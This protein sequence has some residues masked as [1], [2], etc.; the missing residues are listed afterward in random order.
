LYSIH[1]TTFV[2]AKRQKY[3]FAEVWRRAGGL[4][5]SM[6]ASE[7]MKIDD[8]AAPSLA[9]PPLAAALPSASPPR[10]T[11]WSVEAAGEGG[12]RDGC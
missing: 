5:N 6:H 11:R 7:K 1:S 2:A 3:R 8:T 10:A 4:H 9:L 12:G